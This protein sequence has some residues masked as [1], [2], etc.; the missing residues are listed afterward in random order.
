MIRPFLHFSLYQ[1]I[2]I[3]V[4]RGESFFLL[5]TQLT[6]SPCGN[7]TS[8]EKTP[9]SPSHNPWLSHSLVQLCSFQYHLNDVNSQIYISDPHQV[10]QNIYLWRTNRLFSLTYTELNSW[11]LPPNPPHPRPSPYQYWLLSLSLGQARA[12]QSS[13]TPLSISLVPSETPGNPVASTFKIQPEFCHIS[14]PLPL[15]ARS[16]LLLSPGWSVSWLP[17]WTP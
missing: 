13:T 12:W 10:K 16:E 5:S 17:S 6:Y 1:W 8:S 14:V 2:N 9:R 4:E 7:I 3:L 11:S 15:P